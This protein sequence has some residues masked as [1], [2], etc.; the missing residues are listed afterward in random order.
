MLR[1]PPSS[2]SV[3]AM[4]PSILPSSPPSLL[5]DAAADATRSSAVAVGTFDATVDLFFVDVVVIVVLA[6][7]PPLSTSAAC[8]KM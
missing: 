8:I 4:P 1:D 5:L 7:P 2:P 3:V 6:Q